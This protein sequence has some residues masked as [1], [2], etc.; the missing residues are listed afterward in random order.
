MQLLF[1]EKGAEMANRRRQK[2]HNI[3]MLHEDLPWPVAGGY[4]AGVLIL[5]VGEGWIAILPQRT[6]I[7]YSFM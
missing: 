2:H 5:T 6:D 1:L 7:T 3:G 4:A